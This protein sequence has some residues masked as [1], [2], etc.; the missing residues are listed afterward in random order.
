MRWA[1][2]AICDAVDRPNITVRLRLLREPAEAWTAI[3]L[4]PRVVSTASS[5]KLTRQGFGADR[6]QVTMA[7]ATSPETRVFPSETFP[8]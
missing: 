3:T 2:G 7:E 1:P 4:A 5:A 6:G 8:A